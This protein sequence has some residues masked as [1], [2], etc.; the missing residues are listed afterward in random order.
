MSPSASQA[1][2]LLVPERSAR[3]HPLADPH[4][5]R[6]VGT[7]CGLAHRCHAQYVE[8]PT[9]TACF[10]CVVEGPPDKSTGQVGLAQTARPLIETSGYLIGGYERTFAGP[11]GGR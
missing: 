10:D 4:Q 8:L 2:P 6:P 7:E 11:V 5:P 3:G 1:L 9:L